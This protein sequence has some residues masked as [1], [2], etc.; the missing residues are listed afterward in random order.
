MGRVGRDKAFVQERLG[1][2]VGAS[3]TPTECHPGVSF[4]PR[5]GAEPVGD[6][7]QQCSRVSRGDP[8]R[9]RR[10]VNRTEGTSVWLMSLEGKAGHALTN[11]SSSFYFEVLPICEKTA[12]C[13]FTSQ[14]WQEQVPSWGRSYGCQMAAAIGLV[15]LSSFWKPTVAMQKTVITCFI[16]K[17]VICLL[18]CLTLSSRIRWGKAGILLTGPPQISIR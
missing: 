5:A 2:K 9:P 18:V 10:S 14:V 17:N 12:D 15:D 4:L 8:P 7:V 1:K 6:N 3:A 16:R 13:F 11:L